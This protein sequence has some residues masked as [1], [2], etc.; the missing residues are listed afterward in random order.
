MGRSCL[1]KQMCCFQ[2]LET[3][4]AMSKLNLENS[5]SQVVGKPWKMLSS[6]LKELTQADALHITWDGISHD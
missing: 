4:A 1:P 5:V 6:K 3:L 2:N